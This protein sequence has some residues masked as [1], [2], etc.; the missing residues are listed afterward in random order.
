MEPTIY[1]ALKEWN[2]AVQALEQGQTIL[3]VRKGGI[4]EAGGKFTLDHQQILL[5]PTFEHQKPELLKPEYVDQ[6]TTVPSGWHPE[7]IQISSFAEITDM[8]SL[9]TS[10]AESLILK[11]LPLQIWNEKFWRD[12][13]SYKPHKP[14][15]LL[16]LKTYKLPQ[17]YEIPYHPSY[18]GCRSWIDLEKNISLSNLSPVLSSEKYHR[19]RSEILSI[20]FQ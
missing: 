7:T 1:H 14:L 2:V 4:R 3:L 17:V 18:G 16:L 12:R 10:Q 20:L 11:L 13:I 8:I 5:Y 19:I 6:V 15:H 9:E